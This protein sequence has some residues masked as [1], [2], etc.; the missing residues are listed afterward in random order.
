MYLAVNGAEI[1]AYPSEFKVT[2]LDLDDADATYRTADGDFTRDRVAVK[3]QIEMT[4]GALSE[5]KASALLQSMADE[6]FDF[7]YPDI[8]TGTQRT[9]T[10]YVGDRSA[11]VAIYKNGVYWWTDLQMTLTER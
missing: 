3:R 6:F 1:A 9:I 10:V 11:G 2:V 4:F 8:M 7:T 5:D